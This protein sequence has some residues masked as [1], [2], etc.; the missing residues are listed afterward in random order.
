MDSFPFLLD[1][2]GDHV[3]A[4][5]RTHREAAASGIDFETRPDYGEA[6]SHGSARRSCCASMWSRKPSKQIRPLLPLSKH[7]SCSELRLVTLRRTFAPLKH[8]CGAAQE[9]R[10]RL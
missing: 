6:A 4:F 9:T 3:K 10:A 7:R 2:W 1:L 8:L 5:F